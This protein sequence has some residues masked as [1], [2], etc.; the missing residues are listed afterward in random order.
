M[1]EIE[2]LKLFQFCIVGRTLLSLTAFVCSAI[3]YA[4]IK[5][6]EIVF[7]QHIHTFILRK[8]KALRGCFHRSTTFIHIT[9][10]QRCSKET[11]KQHSDIKFT[12][13]CLKVDKDIRIK[14]N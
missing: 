10:C 5:L 7:V 12:G 13:Y 8:M 3:T 1:I 14:R 2:I 11:M 9:D 4:N 6:S